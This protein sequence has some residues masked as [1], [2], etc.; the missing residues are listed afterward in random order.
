MKPILID[1]VDQP[2]LMRK[3]NPFLSLLGE[4][5][6]LIS[7]EYPDYVVFTHEGQRH[8]LYSCTKIFYTQERYRPDWKQCDFA[9]TAAKIEDPRVFH[10]PPYALFLDVNDVIRSPAF[11]PKAE[12]KAKTGFCTFVSG[13]ADRSVRYRTQFFEKL[14]ARKR[15]DSAGRACNNVG[16]T[17]PERM[18]KRQFIRQYKFHLA[19]ENSD[20]AGYTTERFPD[21][22]AAFTVPIFWGDIT[23]KDQFNPQAF[24]DRRDFDSDEACIE[25]ILKADADDSLYLKYLSAPPLKG[26]KPNRPWDRTALLDFFEM[27]FDT[28]PHPVT[29]RRWFFGLTKWRIVKRVKTHAEKGS[30]TA[31]ERYRRRMAAKESATSGRNG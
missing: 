27:I 19:F 26:N 9:L 30:E 14:N 16:F 28:P 11:D 4:R 17:V 6:D 2:A 24:I 29:R 20:V 31:E 10:F 15:V 7:S 3:D 21:A 1:F 12:L 13:Y 23:V 18:P 5:F 22:F 8:R 25:H